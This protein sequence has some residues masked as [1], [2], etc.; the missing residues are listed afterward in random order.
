MKKI[1]LIFFALTFVSLSSFALRLDLS[2]EDLNGGF[3]NAT[4]DPATKTITFTAA[5]SDGKGWWLDGA[6]YSD[7]ED[8]TVNFEATDATVKLVVQYGD[9]TNNEPEVYADAG[10]TTIKVVLDPEKKN[11]VRQIY[12]QKADAGTLVLKEAFLTGSI[13]PSAVLDFED[14]EIG[15]TYSGV[16]WS[17]DAITTT[18]SAN[19]S[20]IGNSLHVVGTNWNSYPKFTV[21]LPEGTKLGDIEKITFDIYF[22]DVEG[23]QNTWKKIDYFF[24]PV[25]ADFTANEPTGTT[26]ENI[27]QSDDKATWLHKEFLLSELPTELQVLS[28]FDFAFGINAE[29]IDYYLDNI[30]FVSTS[31]SLEEVALN[32][33]YYNNNILYLNQVG[34]IQVFDTNGRLVM[35]KEDVTTVDMS[36]ITRGVYIAK[37]MI[38][39]KAEIIKFVK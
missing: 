13:A 14:K 5:W 7:Y 31:S 10:A 23:D 21:S 29:T 37:A 18:V 15:A 26:E 4:Y 35:A 24:G 17:S 25:G 27:I 32:N 2:L 6:D 8:V 33:V 20:G 19:P 11:N 28:S 3:G 38:Q 22:S 34:S 9:E 1:L 39:G 16:G 30:S 12:L 36:S